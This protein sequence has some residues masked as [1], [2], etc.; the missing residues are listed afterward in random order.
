MPYLVARAD[1][2]DDHPANPVHTW[3]L[4]LSAARIKRAYPSIGRL[5][6]L[7]VTR[8]EGG[9]QW[10]G[11]VLR[12]VLDGRRANVRLSGDTFRSVFGL[13]S[14]WFRG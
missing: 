8:R 6:R 11:R 10:H 1:P 9:G 12:V 14:T 7:H 4:R 2:Y 13:R 5:V 3:R